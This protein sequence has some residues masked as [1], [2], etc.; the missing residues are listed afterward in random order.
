MIPTLC[1]RRDPL[2][3]TF[4]DPVKSVVRVQLRELESLVPPS[5][6]LIVSTPDDPVRCDFVDRLSPT[7]EVFVADLCARDPKHIGQSGGVLQ[8]GLQCIVFTLKSELPFCTGE[9]FVVVDLDATPSGREGIESII[10]DGHYFTVLVAD[11]YMTW[12]VDD[13]DISLRVVFNHS[14]KML[15]LTKVR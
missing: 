6:E 9:Y 14:S 4:L 3:R 1:S 2:I 13:G 12:G 7:L 5:F 11:H 15:S 10:C 8:V